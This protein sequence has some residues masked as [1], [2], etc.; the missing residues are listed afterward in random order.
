MSD[1]KKKKK[2]TKTDHFCKQNIAN[3]IK[4]NCNL[5]YQLLRQTQTGK[6]KPRSPF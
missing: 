4:A 3:I 6:K 5:R 1:L 2:K